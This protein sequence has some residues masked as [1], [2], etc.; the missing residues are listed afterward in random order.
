MKKVGANH[1]VNLARGIDIELA[2]KLIKLGSAVIKS[3]SPDIELDEAA[4][5]C[6][7]VVKVAGTVLTVLGVFIDG[8]VLIIAAFKGAEQREQLEAYVP[9]VALYREP[10]APCFPSPFTFPS[11][12]PLITVFMLGQSTT[13]HTAAS[14]PKPS[15][16]WAKFTRSTFPPCTPWW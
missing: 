3:I 2:Q 14:A 6:L 1:L 10:S 13:F 5:K 12:S 7:N 4:L 15:L 8:V 9:A 11:T 16:S